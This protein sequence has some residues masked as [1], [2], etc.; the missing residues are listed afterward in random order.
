F[1]DVVQSIK[2]ILTTIPP[3]NAAVS[4]TSRT[5]AMP[6]PLVFKIPEAG[7]HFLEKPDHDWIINMVDDVIRNMSIVGIK[8]LLHSILPDSLINSINFR[9]ASR[10]IIETMIDFLEVRGALNPPDFHALGAF[11]NRLLENDSI[12]YTVQANI[13]ALL[14]KYTLITDRQQIETL[15]ARFQVPSPIPIDQQINSH[16]FALPPSSSDPTSAGNEQERIE[17]LHN[18]RRLLLNEKSLR[19]EAKAARSV[20]RIDFNMHTEGT[21]FLIAPDLILTNYHVM[22]PPGFEGDIDARARGCEIKFGV[23]EGEKPGPHFTLHPTDWRLAESKTEELD[24]MVL[25]LNREVTADDQIEPL[26]LQPNSVQKDAF[27]NI[28]QHS[29][30]QAMAVRLSFD[31]VVDVDDQRIYYLANTVEG[32]SGAPVFDDRWRLV[33]LHH[34][35]GKIDATD[36]APIAANIGIPINPIIRA[37]RAQMPGLLSDE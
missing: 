16:P 18:H 2:Q 12:N 24:F 17:R 21:G 30:G 9:A 28:I 13:V 14:F 15:S 22:I 26:T 6:Q 5:P 3:T 27:V 20:C 23:I 35:S 11:L 4:V 10:N 8:N 25:K 31:Q 36:K 34:A 19:E 33:A 32:S 37:I 1:V 7:K 29:A